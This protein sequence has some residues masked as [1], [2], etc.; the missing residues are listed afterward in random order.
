M[1]S[2]AGWPRCDQCEDRRRDRQLGRPQRHG[3]RIERLALVVDEYGSVEGIVT[4]TDLLEAVAGDI[5]ESADEELDVVER[6]D[7]SLLM[8][9]MMA[10]YEALDRLG[11]SV[12]TE[13]AG[14]HTLAGF[15]IHQLGR[16]PATGDHFVWRGWRFEV[17]DMDGQRIEKMLVSRTP[18]DSDN[19]DQ[20]R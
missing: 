16:I 6:G 11:I 17:V 3:E 12:M 7:G 13:H 2:P 9:G 15:V 10:A 18:R 1:H 5:P 14:F 20:A 8:N 4:Q 19:H